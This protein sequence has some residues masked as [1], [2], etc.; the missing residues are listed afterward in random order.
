[1]CR[2]CSAAAVPVRVPRSQDGPIR[3]VGVFRVPRMPRMFSL[4]GSGG[5]GRHLGRV[6]IGIH[7]HQHPPRHRSRVCPRNSCHARGRVITCIKSIMRI[8][9]DS[10]NSGGGPSGILPGG[11]PS[12]S[13]LA[14]M[15]A[16][17]LIEKKFGSCNYRRRGGCA[18][19]ALPTR[20]PLRDLSQ[21]G[22]IRAT[23][24]AYARATPERA[25]I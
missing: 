22:S 9:V 23:A 10:E 17:F 14:R 5:G 1:M 13:P 2:L 16:Q 24:R 8:P 11:A 3:P 6:S 21:R 19:G 15:P 25:E 4:R 12:A 20:G 18:S 7:F